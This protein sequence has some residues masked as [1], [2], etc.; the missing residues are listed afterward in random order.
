M[1]LSFIV[2]CYN[3]EKNIK[4]FYNE[5]D[6]FFKD[7]K[8]S[9]ELVF[10]NDGSKDNTLNELKKILKEKNF[11]VKIINFSRNFGKEAALYAGLKNCTGDYAVLIDADMQQPPRLVLKMLGIIEKEKDVDIVAYYQEKRI[12]NKMLSFL[13][14]CF[15]KFIKKS[16]GLP[17]VN[18][19]S[20]FRLINRNV[21]NSILNFSEHYRFSK[22]I[23]AY[24]GFN[25]YYLPYIPEKRKCGKSSWSFKKLFKYGEN[26][27]LSFV[28][29]PNKIITNISIVTFIVSLVLFIFSLY[30]NFD[31]L[32][33]LIIFMFSINFA[34]I[35][36]M[37][38]FIHRNYVE[39][40]D[41]P[42]YIEKEVISNDKK[43]S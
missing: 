7:L 9:I 2:P 14:K 17:F 41:R 18:G 27:V 16:T 25:T 19:A 13:K 37:F 36:F 28:N 22:G 3:E 6:K 24:I 30:N 32:Y 31:L 8:Y 35:S 4:L 11:S 33:S 29:N 5:I 23:F 39:L 34:I 15:Y 42:I 21:I 40:I 43:S 20:D 38:R 12:E 10:I 26:G 1:K